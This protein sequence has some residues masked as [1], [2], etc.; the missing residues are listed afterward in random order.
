MLNSVSLLKRAVMLFAALGATTGLAEGKAAPHFTPT[1]PWAMDHANDGC[2]L[3]R[4]FSDGRSQLTLAF[5]RFTLEPTLRLRLTTNA[6]R[7]FPP[8][9]A[10]EFQYDDAMPRTSELLT[11]VLIHGGATFRLPAA[12]LIPSEDLQRASPTAALKSAL[13]D[14]LKSETEIAEHVSAITISKGFQKTIVIDLGS[15]VQP[16]K[17]MQQCAND[18]VAGWGVDISRLLTQSRPATP[19]NEVFN[20]VTPDDYPANM[21]MFGFGGL[22]RARL[23]V[24]ADGTISK[25]MVDTTKQGQ[26]QQLVCD[27]L[28]KRA[29]FTAAL[30]ADGKPFRSYW[31]GTWRFSMQ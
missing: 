18:L 25:C 20:W 28:L 24:D 14:L 2:R 4:N 6:L 15:M 19:A 11:A 29:K 30:D 22:V 16:V 7:P 12:S 26:L 21:A 31:E 23:I 10:A 5:E 17:A 8:K 13:P 3:T 1:D 9:G 27:N